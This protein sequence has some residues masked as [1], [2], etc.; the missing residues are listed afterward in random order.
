MVIKRVGPVSC[1]KIVGVLYVILGLVFGGM[2]SLM[3]LAGG[4]G[5]DTA[6]AVG[7]GML[8]GAGAI[9]ILPIMYGC[10]GFVMTLFMAWMYNLLA[11][12]VGGI[13]VDLQ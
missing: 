9:I 6:G 4:F 3:S 10:F 5:A 8:M 1:A 12:V 7:L 11:G 2:F 13:E